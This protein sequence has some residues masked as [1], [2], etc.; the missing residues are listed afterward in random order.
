L[1]K[2]FEGYS[3]VAYKDT[4][5]YDTIGFGHLIDQGRRY[6]NR[7]WPRPPERLLQ[8]DIKPKAAA[9]N[10]HVSVTL[11]QEQFDAVGS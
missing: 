7:F 1:I 9:V 3:P 10:G 11:F 4:A 2:H 6:R 8:Q 5:G